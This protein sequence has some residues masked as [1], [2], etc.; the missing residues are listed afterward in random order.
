VTFDAVMVNPF[1]AATAMAA[2]W[3]TEKL[4]PL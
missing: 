3:A 1:F 4:E 2:L